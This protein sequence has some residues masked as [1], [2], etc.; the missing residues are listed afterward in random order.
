MYTITLNDL[1]EL[2]Y[3]IFPDF[4]FPT[5]SILGE[6]ITKQDFIDKFYAY[7]GEYQIAYP[8]PSKFIFEVGRIFN[9]NY[10]KFLKQIDVCNSII[11]SLDGYK[12][13]IDRDYSGTSKYSDTPNQTIDAI[14]DSNTYLSSLNKD[15]EEATTTETYSTNEIEKFDDVRK[16]IRNVMYDFFDLFNDCFLTYMSTKT[17]YHIRRI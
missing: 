3:E 13:V 1:K 8:T 5:V 6:S 16:K 17:Y 15:S 4:D 9:R 2:G 7:Y 12:R 11:Y 14:S 10:Q